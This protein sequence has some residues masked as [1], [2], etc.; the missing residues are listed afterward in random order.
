[1]SL[2]YRNRGTAVIS[3]IPAFKLLILLSQF[4]CHVKK[5]YEYEATFMPKKKT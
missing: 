3:I 1:M 4:S 2:I 5:Q